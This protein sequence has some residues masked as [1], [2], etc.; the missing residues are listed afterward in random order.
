MIFSSTNALVICSSVSS[1]LKMSATVLSDKQRF[2]YLV[3]DISIEF[4]NQWINDGGVCKAVPGFARSAKYTLRKLVLIFI[5]CLSLNL[6]WGHMIHAVTRQTPSDNCHYMQNTPLCLPSLPCKTHF[7]LR[8]ITCHHITV[9][10]PLW[11]MILPQCTM[12]LTLYQ[13]PIPQTRPSWEHCMC[14]VTRGGIYYE[15]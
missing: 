12:Y 11:K 2:S 1:S 4:F 3:C 9:G 14:I 13:C 8:N 10:A 5:L 15:I 7:T 6:W